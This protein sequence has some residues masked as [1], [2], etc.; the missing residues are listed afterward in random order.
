MSSFNPETF[1]SGEVKGEME[2]KYTPVPEDDYTAFVH[3]V[4]AREINDTPV[5]DVIYKILDEAL[6]ASMDAEDIFVRQSIFVD[7][8]GDGNIQF[9]P[10]KNVKLGQLRD[11]CGQNTKA[12]W[13]PSMLRGGGPLMIRVTQRPDKNDPE[14]VYND[15]KRV[16]AAA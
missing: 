3:D 5:L 7:V 14:T 8:D 12:M 6:Q 10:N 13:T 4:A 2:T 11:A 9:G 16:A 1:L 15:V